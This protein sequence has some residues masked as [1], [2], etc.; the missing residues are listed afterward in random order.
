MYNDLVEKP[1]DFSKIIEDYAYELTNI[2]VPPISSNRFNLI[3][4]YSLSFKDIIIYPLDEHGFEIFDLD[5]SIVFIK[6]NMDTLL[7]I[8]LCILSES[9]IVFMSR[10]IG[11]LTPIIQIFFKLIFPFKWLLP[12]VPLLPCSQLEYL[13]APHPFIMGIDADLVYRIDQ[14]L[15][16][17]LLDLML[18]IY[19]FFMA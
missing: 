13:E 19:N 18:F 12:Y 3:L 11:L 16:Y 10:S 2:P 8:I 6:F 4:E 15:F 9:K 14:V 17:L 1:Q 7:K 5:I